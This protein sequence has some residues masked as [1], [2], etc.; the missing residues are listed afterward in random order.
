MTLLTYNEVMKLIKEEGV[1][2]C[3]EDHDVKKTRCETDCKHD[4]KDRF[5][6]EKIYCQKCGLEWDVRHD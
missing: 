6:L 5:I 2:T 4:Y 3:A 1:V